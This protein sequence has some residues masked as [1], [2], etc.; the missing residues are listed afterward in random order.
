MVLH[1]FCELKDEDEMSARNQKFF[2]VLFDFLDHWVVVTRFILWRMNRKPKH[3][4]DRKE[5]L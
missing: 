5:L 2:D 3:E 4:R 1:T